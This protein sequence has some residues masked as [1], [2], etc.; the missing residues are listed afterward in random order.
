MSGVFETALPRLRD[1]ELIARRAPSPHNTQPWL[2]HYSNDGIRLDYDPARHLTASDPHM[3]DLL[4]ALGGFVECL[5]I[6]SHEAR[7]PIRFSTDLDLER[8]HVGWFHPAAI[9]YETKFTSKDILSRQTSRLAYRPIAIV[10]ELGEA[11]RRCLSPGEAI[12]QVRSS[13]I[14]NLLPVADRHFLDTPEIAM[15]F[16]RWCR[17]TPAEIAGAED[18]LTAD[19]LALSAFEARI[20]SL[21]LRPRTHPWFRFLR[22]SL[23]I[24]MATRTLVP[25]ASGLMALVAPSESQEQVLATGRTL[26]RLWL[27]LS[28]AGVHAQPLS[29]VLDCT[30]TARALHARL[31]FGSGQRI[32]CLFRFGV[33]HAPARSRRIVQSWERPALEE[34]P[35]GGAL[36][37]QQSPDGR[38]L[39]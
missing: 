13:D 15:E 39:R 19:C 17:L 10:G 20:L 21:A 3:R 9:E 30:E 26:M 5:L 7:I 12:V 24:S 32:L 22:L 25:E 11:L 4:L 35:A 29:Q 36:Q 6:A 27:A 8:R 18:G 34:S 33:S 1:L 28:R 37:T 16:R 2:L 23:A 31:G 14:R 38:L